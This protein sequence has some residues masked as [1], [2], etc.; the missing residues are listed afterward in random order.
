M[1]VNS[2]KPYA[3]AATERDLCREKIGKEIGRAKSGR[4]GWRLLRKAAERR[5]R[6]QRRELMLLL[7]GAAVAAPLTAGAQQKAM[8]VI[9][10]LHSASPAAVAVN[11]AA[12]HQSLRENG[13][14]VGQNE[15]AG[16]SRQPIVVPLRPA[17]FDRHE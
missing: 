8:R 6:M 3:S 10:F 9:G 17:I 11:L 13:Y 1:P 2:G 5:K 14:V 16:H 4:V 15:I 12:F 7:G